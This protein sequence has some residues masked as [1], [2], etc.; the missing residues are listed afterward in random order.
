MVVAM[1][2][3]MVMGEVSEVSER[4]SEAAS[5]NPPPSKTQEP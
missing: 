4:A 1:V 5:T 3:V 2:M